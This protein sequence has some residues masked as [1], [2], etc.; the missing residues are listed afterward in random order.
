MYNRTL[1]HDSERPLAIHTDDDFGSDYHTFDALNDGVLFNFDECSSISLIAQYFQLNKKGDVYNN[2]SVRSYHYKKK[3]DVQHHLRA[4]GGVNE[5]SL[6][7]G[8][9]RIAYQNKLI[10]V[11]F[12]YGAGFGGM[13]T[14]LELEG[15]GRDYWENGDYTIS[16]K[17]RKGY[18]FQG[19]GGNVHAGFT[20]NFKVSKRL[21][22]FLDVEVQSHFHHLRKTTAVWHGPELYHYDGSLMYSP[23]EVLYENAYNAFGVA[24]IIGY[25]MHYRF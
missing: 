5:L 16:T 22:I 13:L 25:G 8:Q 12:N 4:T 2:L 3:Y 18:Q 20:L 17:K 19:V 6:N 7:L 10:E 21:D 11:T 23:G 9:N 15:A 14:S 24:G 1:W